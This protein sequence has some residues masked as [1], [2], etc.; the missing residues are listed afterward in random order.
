MRI[1]HK[2]IPEQ[3]GQATSNLSEMFRFLT[4][5][6]KP[7]I[8]ISHEVVLELTVTLDPTSVIL[9]K[10]NWSFET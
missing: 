2:E 4:F 9:Y 7:G 6:E 10:S 5:C 8:S 1:Q 3:S